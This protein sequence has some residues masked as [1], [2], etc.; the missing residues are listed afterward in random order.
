ME[1]YKSFALV[2]DL[3]MQEV[4]YEE[5]VKYIEKIWERFN[6]FPELMAELGCG[7]GNL[8]T[9]FAKKG[10]DMIGIDN[11]PDMLTIAKEK[12]LSEHLDIL[13]LLQDMREF[14]LY[15]TV[16]CIISLCDSLNYILDEED[17]LQ[18]FKWVNNYLNPGGLFIFD[19]NT[20]YKYKY[21]LGDNIFADS[22]DEAAFIWNNFYDEDKALNEY[23]LTL[24]IRQEDTN[25][26]ERYEEIHYEK[27]YSVSQL[28]G[29]IEKAGLE[30]LAVYDAY[31]FDPP[32]ENSER[33]FFVAREKGKTD[34]R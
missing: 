15:G 6:C 3:F 29:L 27:M 2:Y 30:F 9:L 25:L 19:M 12:A 8:T 32:K 14:E 20:E 31:S 23:H 24:F 18:T 21:I 7:T 13:Y 28:I 16:D 4:P 26:Y 11:S 33:L 22:Y 34:R 10:I 5:W 1:P 17:L